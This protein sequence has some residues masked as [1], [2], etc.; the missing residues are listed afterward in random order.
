MDQVSPVQ[1]QLVKPEDAAI[2]RNAW[3]FVLGHD[4]SKPTGLC[5]LIDKVKP[6]FNAFDVYAAIK[7][8]WA[9]LY[10]VSRGAHVV[11]WFCGY[12]QKRP[13]SG[14]AEWFL[15]CAYTI[16]LRERLPDDDVPDAVRQSIAFMHE[17]RKQA[18][19]DRIVMLSTR[20]GFERW[21]FVKSFTTWYLP[22]I[23]TTPKLAF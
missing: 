10:I 16:P 4:G 9:Q 18:G 23:D 14:Q 21:G 6:D 15:W 2:L 11:G 17:L 7:Q 3:T 12:V 19:G 13:F 1:I 22:Q 5:R 20:R 8:G